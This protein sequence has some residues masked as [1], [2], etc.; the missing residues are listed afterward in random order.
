MIRIE[1]YEIDDDISLVLCRNIKKLFTLFSFKENTTDI[2]DPKN[3]ISFWQPKLVE[4]YCYQ[5]KN[6][7]AIWQEET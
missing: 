1:L 6:D 2:Y 7:R 4:K 5:G 3:P